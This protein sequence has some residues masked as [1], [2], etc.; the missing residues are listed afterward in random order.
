V[1]FERARAGKKT[2]EGGIMTGANGILTGKDLKSAGA[3]AE[4][5][6]HGI[7]ISYRKR[8]KLVVSIKRYLLIFF[9][10]YITHFDDSYKVY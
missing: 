3:R 5:G 9:K 10:R 8:Q 1:E 2:G 4:V 6:S 7:T